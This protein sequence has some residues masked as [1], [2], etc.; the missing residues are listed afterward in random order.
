MHLRPLPTVHLSVD[1]MTALACPSQSEL[2]AFDRGYLSLPSIDD[3]TRHLEHCSACLA[4]L[5]EFDAPADPLQDLLGQKHG[6]GRDLIAS[7]HD[8]SALIDR[9]AA[10]AHSTLPHTITHWDSP[11]PPAS[12]LPAAV[13]TELGQYRLLSEL[14]HGG[15][16]TVF[17][18]LHL[19]LE[20][21]VALKVLSPE[22]LHDPHA[23]ARFEREM[24]AVGKLHHPRIVAAHDAG[25][26]AGAHFLVME[27][28]DGVDLA[29]LVRRVGPLP[30]A[31]ACELVRQAA[32]GLQAIYEHGFVHRDIKPSNLMLTRDGELKILDL[33]L[34]LLQP[35]SIAAAQSHFPNS[36]RA[37]EFES[38]PPTHILGTVDYLAPEQARDSRAVDIRADLYGLGCT[39]VTLLTGQP[40]YPA[41]QWKTVEQKIAAHGSS[42]LPDLR[43][44][45]PEIPA[46][47][48]CVI[49]RL[50]AK[51]PKDRYPTPAAAGAA[52]TPF[53][54][55]ANLTG[56]LRPNELLRRN[57][58]LL[59]CNTELLLPSPAWGRGAGGEGASAPSAHHSNKRPR[60]RSIAAIMLIALLT[61]SA[62][63]FTTGEGTLALHL[64]E[65]GIQ[66][67]LDGQAAPSD[68]RFLP[69]RVEHYLTAAAGR[70]E[71]RARVQL[72]PASITGSQFDGLVEMTGNKR[73]SVRRRFWL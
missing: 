59:R 50:L 24:K 49:Q 48:I 13:P 55:G 39:L 57:T 7:G 52:L 72:M 46:E 45:R 43:Q 18:A 16:G 61:T 3:L 21:L 11:P 67:E 6:G 31:E 42:P 28:V 54:Y 68:M 14:G 27:L 1:A 64:R 19:K 25:E 40:P 36:E 10:L 56:F 41:P 60:N 51:N 17:K 65:P 26:A 12:E 37:V 66:I 71:L 73:K 32:E 38:A 62:G 47:L 63:Y 58:E 69:H 9:A 34:A 30:I 2:A 23:V 15:M 53:A 4:L 22:R 8:L 35:T 20:K 5:E 44:R 70:H 29:S 33:G